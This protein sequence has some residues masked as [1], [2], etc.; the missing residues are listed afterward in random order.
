MKT[1]VKARGFRDIDK[2]MCQKMFQLYRDFF[3]L[4]QSYNCH[5][6][7]TPTVEFTELFVRGVG[8]GTDVVDKEMFTFNYDEESLC[9]V[10]EGTAGTVRMLINQG[11]FNGRYFYFR[12][13]FRKERPQKGRYRE[14]FSIG[15]EFIG[16]KDVLQDMEC[17]NL[18]IDFFDLFKINYKLKINTIGTAEDRQI[19]I[20]VLRQFF[21]EN[22]DQLSETSKTR[23]N[24]GKILRILD[25]KED[26]E[27]L[28][29]AP[30]ILDYL[31]PMSLEKFRQIERFLSTKNIDFEI[32]P[33]I[34]RGLDYYNDLVFEFIGKNF[35]GS[36]NAICG[37]GRYDGL[38]ETLGGQP[39][40]AVGFGIG[41]DRVVE[42]MTTS[43]VKEENCAVIVDV[44]N[45]EIQDGLGKLRS[46]VTNVEVLPN[47]IKAVSKARKNFDKLFLVSN[48]TIVFEN[49]RT[50]EKKEVANWQE[51]GNLFVPKL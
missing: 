30:K 45:Q 20:K 26:T 49:L 12:N 8:E 7:R 1:L 40:Q 36:Q 17:L 21:C 25:S 4:A 9:L 42:V 48:G 18:A 34:V 41:L 38:F 14:F 37:G 35:E 24:S 50:N 27:L 47:E 28:S 3:L 5:E 43:L 39:T 15:A 19:F 11:V 10:P 31:N 22:F 16:R 33:S 32:D 51:V 13:F 2:D 23:F 44:L 29:R 46:L 6:I